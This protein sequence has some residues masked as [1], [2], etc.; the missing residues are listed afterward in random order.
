MWEVTTERMRSRTDEEEEEEGGRRR[1]SG[2]FSWLTVL[3]RPREVFS[4]RRG[5]Q[6][7]PPGDTHRHTHTHTLHE[8]TVKKEV[9]GH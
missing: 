8:G 7:T 6:R 4:L 9:K 2:V 3:G 5:R 1:G